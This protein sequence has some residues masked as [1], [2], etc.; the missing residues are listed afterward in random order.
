M[1]IKY[2]TCSDPREFNDINEIIDLA[3]SSPRAEIAIQMHPSKASPGMP[4][5]EWLTEL[6]KKLQSDQ[7]TNYILGRKYLYG[8]INLAVHINSEW[9]TKICQS[10]KFPREL[11]PLLCLRYTGGFDVK[12]IIRRIQINVPKDAAICASSIDMARMMN[13]NR[14]YKF[15][16]QYNEKTADLVHRLYRIG[17][18]FSP[19][20]DASGGNGISPDAWCGPVFDYGWTGYSGGIS[21]ENVA[22]NL[23]KI[24]AVVPANRDIWIDAEGKLKTDNKFDIARARQYIKNA[25]NWIAGQKQR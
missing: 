10:G 2:I 21:P 15:I 8:L 11:Y 4:R 23:T 9:A 16:I 13:E 7:Y 12:P 1:N 19:L 22:N 3:K 25:E 14:D 17:A 6:L 20:Y 24:S 18:N 5:Y